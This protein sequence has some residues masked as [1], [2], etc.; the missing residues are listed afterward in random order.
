MIH[1]RN[2]MQNE[3]IDREHK[4][5]SQTYINLWLLI[6]REAKDQQLDWITQDCYEHKNSRCQNGIE[7]E[8]Q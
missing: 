2:Q 4:I 5:P 6:Y 8:T 1:V 3:Y 7:E